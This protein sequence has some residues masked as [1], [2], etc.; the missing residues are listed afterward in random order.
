MALPIITA[1][2][3]LAE[4]RGV[5]GCIFGK[6]GIGK[7]SLLWTLDPKTTL[8]LDLE[9]GDLAIEGWTGDALR[10]RTWAECRD[11]AVFIGGPNPALRSDQAYGEAHFAAVAERFG[12]P[13]V[14]DLYETL[15][16]DSITVAG[17]LCFQWCR[18]QPEAIS[19]KSGKPDVR[20]AYGLHGREM[21]GWLTQLQHAR[22][23]NV[24]FVG[25]LDERTDDFN[26]RV[27]SPQIDGSKTGLELP[28][29]V[30]EVLTM[31]EVKAEDGA[32][33]RA[34][35]CQTLNPLG[36]PA[37]DRSGRLDL[38]EEPHLG[39]LMAK[40]R[41]TARQPLDFSGHLP[42]QPASNTVS[43]SQTKE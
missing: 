32:N 36:F 30:D 25:I 13:S 2:Q 21:I 7:T 37:K 6:S 9:A 41:G 39:R 43:N 12:P 4:A 27:F 29:I 8:F 22:A 23:K 24:W 35:I 5:K 11:L 19:E 34:F 14:L 31:A 17:R 10:P 28:G 26:R 33:R 16:V 18:G 42:G 20:G 3:R 38:V 15:F 40:I 1:D